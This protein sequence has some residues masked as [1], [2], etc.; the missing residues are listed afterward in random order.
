MTGV[1]PARHVVL[2][3]LM[4]TGKTTVGRLVAAQLGRPLVD[5]DDQVEARTGRTVRDIWQS[6]GE[7][8][9]R[10]LESDALASALEDPIPTVVAAAGGVVLSAEN[11][12]RLAA[13]DAVV[14]WLRAEPSTLAQRVADADDGHRPLL[15]AD[16]AGKLEDMARHR[17]SLYR[18]VADVIVDVDDL[19]PIQVTEAVLG[20]IG[21]LE[22]GADER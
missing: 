15:D 14:V 16:P 18:S 17:T 2:V 22:P 5:S 11:R 8:A 21:A 13:D 20:A 7:A 4:A 9:F 12:E 6:D 10:R 19:G 3:G 1:P